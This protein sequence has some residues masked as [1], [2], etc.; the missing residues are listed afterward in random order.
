MVLYSSE[1]K[2]ISS[3]SG[4][5]AEMKIGDRGRISRMPTDEPR[6]C[7]ALF[8][9]VKIHSAVFKYPSG[10]E[11]VLNDV[12]I[13]RSEYPLRLKSGECPHIVTIDYSPLALYVKG[14][15]SEFAVSVTP[16][17]QQKDLGNII[18]NVGGQEPQKM[19]DIK[20]GVTSSWQNLGGQEPQKM[21]DVKFGVTSSW[22]E[23]Q[24]MGDVKFGVASSWQEPSKSGFGFSQP[25]Q[26]GGGMQ[27]VGGG[28]MLQ[29]IAQQQQQQNVG[30]LM[31]RMGQP[32][33]LGGGIQ[34]VGGG[35]MQRMG[36]FG[37]IQRL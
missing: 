24:K 21:G 33:Q 12:D 34:S 4:N 3:M 28:G 15:T 19:G 22:Q 26:L 17:Q 5:A 18:Q 13:T 9:N 16:Q 7:S 25:Q 23:P 6:A 36:P 35:G 14:G 8:V 30:T 11:Q 20:F 31:Q 1:G 32:Q 29:N 37:T 27:S 10:A 2:T